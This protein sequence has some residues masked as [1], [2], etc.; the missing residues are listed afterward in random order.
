MGAPYMSRAI[1]TTSMAR[2]TPAQK[3]RGLNRM[4]FFTA[5]DIGVAMEVP[6][7]NKLAS[8][9]EPRFIVNKPSYPGL[10]SNFQNYGHNQRAPRGFLVQESLQVGADLL[11][12]HTPVATLLGRRSLERFQGDLARLLQHTVII[13]GDKSAADD[14]RQHL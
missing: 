8:P 9:N 14:F 4:I 5:T 13:L 10:P 3:P 6:H 2:T 1:F 12:H 7:Y 11:L